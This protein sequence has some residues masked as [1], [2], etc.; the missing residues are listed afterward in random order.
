MTVN[1]KR[2]TIILQFMEY[3]RTQKGLAMPF[4]SCGSIELKLNTSGFTKQ[5][6]TIQKIASFFT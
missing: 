1:L 3:L 2:L 5:Y 4:D 6:N